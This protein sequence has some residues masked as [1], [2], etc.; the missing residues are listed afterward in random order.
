MVNTEETR[1]PDAAPRR[2]AAHQRLHRRG[3]TERDVGRMVNQERNV[4]AALLV[5]LGG[6][7]V[8][9]MSNAMSSL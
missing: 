7:L 6:V 3:Y 2:I 5:A 4:F 1:K 9:E 8:I